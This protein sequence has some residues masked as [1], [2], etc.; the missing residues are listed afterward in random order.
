[1]GKAIGRFG[2]ADDCFGID[3]PPRLYGRAIV[4]IHPVE[5]SKE[6]RQQTLK[7]QRQ[8]LPDVEKP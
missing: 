2:L 3:H 8:P 5:K 1:M 7:L 4:P 6:I